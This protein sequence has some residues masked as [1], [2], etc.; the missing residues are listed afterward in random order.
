MDKNGRLVTKHVRAGSKARPD[1]KLPV[2][3]LGSDRYAKAADILTKA[4][5]HKGAQRRRAEERLMNMGP[6]S[7]ALLEEL[8]EAKKYEGGEKSYQFFI[9]D[10]LTKAP[11]SKLDS[12]LRNSLA[13]K[14]DVEYMLDMKMQR[15][16][17]EIPEFAPYADDLGAHPDVL[18]RARNLV[19]FIDDLNLNAPHKAVKETPSVIRLENR[20]LEK[21][22]IEDR[23]KADEFIAWASDN[24]ESSSV[25]VDS[26]DG[27]MMLMV[28]NNPDIREEMADLIIHGG[29]TDSKLIRLMLVE[30]P[31]DKERIKGYLS[32][33]VDRVE[34][35]TAL[36]DQEVQ[37]SLSSGVL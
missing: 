32:E 10:L 33:G 26:C 1:M 4:G 19:C 11:E 8:V 14:E 3:S 36:L 35:L 20:E 9:E 5:L 22:L 21:V 31:E 34:V 2:P 7:F 18:A 28:V 23:S 13:F 25:L 37:S 6:K 27:D 29:L 24:G 12:Y 15:A 17:H 30:R 16:M